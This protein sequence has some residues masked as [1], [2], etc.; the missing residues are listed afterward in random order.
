E[1]DVIL[2]KGSKLKLNV[3]S[4]ISTT[5]PS[6]AYGILTSGNII[7]NGAKLDINLY[8]DINIYDEHDYNQY[9]CFGISIANRNNTKDITITDSDITITYDNNIEKTDEHHILNRTY[10]IA[11]AY[12]HIADDGINLL[13]I[14][15]SNIDIDIEGKISEICGLRSKDFIIANS[16]VDI[17]IDCSTDEKESITGINVI[18]NDNPK[19]ELLW[20]KDSNVNI[21]IN[22][23]IQKDTAGI[24]C[25]YLEIELKD[26]GY[27]VNIDTNGGYALLSLISYGEEERTYDIDYEASKIALKDNSI[28][29]NKEKINIYSYDEYIGSKSFEE[30]PYYYYETLYKNKEKPVS[31]LLVT[32][33]TN[34][35]EPTPDPKPTPKPVP[36]V[37]PKTGIN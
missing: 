10:G 28:L 12:P 5:A 29:P 7:I 33:H 25:D 31:K 37:A 1:N 26:E 20:I 11:N 30:H 13:S 8:T 21:N 3:L 36:Y 22:S 23:D 19:D 32:G 4:Y 14:E 6:M 24:N 9:G 17:N 34:K 27:A 35:P 16:N 2:E 18:R 15:N